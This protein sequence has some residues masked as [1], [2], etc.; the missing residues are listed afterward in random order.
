MKSRD[1]NANDLA[2][3]IGVRASTIYSLI[4]RDS[5][6]I[7]INLIVKIARALGVDTDELLNGSVDTEFCIDESGKIYFVQ[8]RPLINVSGKSVFDISATHLPAP[9]AVGK[10]SVGGVNIGKIKVIDGFYKLATGEL[11]ITPE[12]IVVAHRTE[13]QWSQSVFSD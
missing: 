8:V 3:R 9:I 4:Q 13:N 11:K 1:T 2:Q 6:R 12:D 7:D 10:Y 5:N